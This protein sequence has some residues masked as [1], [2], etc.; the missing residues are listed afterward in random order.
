MAPVWQLY[1]PLYHRRRYVC[2]RRAASVSHRP[3]LPGAGV[4]GSVRRASQERERS[5]STSMQGQWH[6]RQHL[7]AAFCTLLLVGSLIPVYYLHPGTLVAPHSSRHGGSPSVLPVD[8]LP[9]GQAKVATG[10]ADIAQHQPQIRGLAGNVVRSSASYATPM[11]P[12][13]APLQP[14]TG[15]WGLIQLQRVPA[16]THGRLEPARHRARGSGYLASAA[17]SR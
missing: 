9:A 5:M 7:A 6:V 15:A 14:R 10:V 16:D 1:G 11:T 17:V 3:G 2:P 4:S 13:A 12:E 8:S